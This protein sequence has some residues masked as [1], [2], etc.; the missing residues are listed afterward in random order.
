MHMKGTN[1]VIR[2][3]CFVSK[4]NTKTLTDVKYISKHIY[5]IWYKHFKN[6]Q[7]EKIYITRREKKERLSHIINLYIYKDLKYKYTGEF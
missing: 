1:R 2:L 6:E 7:N 5:L 3:L 4:S